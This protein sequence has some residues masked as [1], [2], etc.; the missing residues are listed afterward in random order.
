MRKFWVGFLAFFISIN[1]FSVAGATDWNDSNFSFKYFDSISV[2][3]AM[4]CK[5]TLL[6]YDVAGESQKQTVCI[7][8]AGP[9]K[10]G[11]YAGSNGYNFVVGFH[12]D[13]TLYK[14]VDFDCDIYCIYSPQYDV[15]IA[16]RY[17]V[18]G[19]Q[20]SLTITENFSSRLQS[21]INFNNLTTYFRVT[22]NTP[23]SMFQYDGN[24]FGVNGLGISNNGRYV[25]FEVRQRGIL[26]MDLSNMSLKRV[27]NYGYAYGYGM[28]PGVDLAITNDGNNLVATGGNAG[29]TIYSGLL[30]CG[31]EPNAQKIMD[32][33]PLDLED[34]CPVYYPNLGIFNTGYDYAFAPK[35]TDSG[36]GLRFYAYLYNQG[37]KDIFL[38]LSDS[39]SNQ[40][41]LL[42]LGDSYSSGEGE[43]DHLQYQSSTDTDF[44]NC[45]T[46]LRSYPYLVA[47]T[48]GYGSLVKNVS[49]S[50]AVTG[51]IMG[52]TSDFYWGQKGRLKTI[53]DQNQEMAKE[54]QNQALNNFTPGRIAQMDFVAE[55]QP[56]VITIGIGGNDVGLVGK[57]KSCLMPTT[58]H[59][60]SDP[61]ER[62]KLAG[63]IKSLYDD[64]QKVYLTALSKSP[65]SRIY[66]VSY[67]QII[68]QSSPCDPLTATLF[69][70]TERLFMR[71]TISYLNQV[72]Q[73]AALNVGVKYINIEDVY[74]N[75]TL[76]GQAQASVMNGIVT[77]D[78][79]GVLF[80]R[81]IGNESFHPKPEGHS[82]A[83]Q[84]IISQYPYILDTSYCY[85]NSNICPVATLA[86]N[87]SSYWTAGASQASLDV[88][89]KQLED[90]TLPLDSSSLDKTIAMPAY[91]FNSGSNVVASVHSDY[92]E[93]G[94]FTANQDGSL[95]A[96]LSFPSSLEYGYHTLTLKG[97]TFTGK[98]V[99][100]QQLIF[101]KK[102][103]PQSQSEANNNTDATSSG[104]SSSVLTTKTASSS[105]AS[106]ILSKEK[107]VLGVT[108]SKENFA[109]KQPSETKATYDLFTL[110]ILGMGALSLGLLGAG[111]IKRRIN[112]KLKY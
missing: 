83:A 93:L 63:Q 7:N 53:T 31:D 54:L 46:S 11:Y 99:E 70:A 26:V 86:P 112:N 97:E 72:I 91:S 33:T 56:E 48:F 32:I 96:N 65:K 28:D 90:D 29:F 100:Y 50:G 52:N 78:D 67:P 71:E 61:D 20:K 30:N 88:I 13:R 2:S 43:T 107:A 101:Y 8:E 22:D 24:I 47:S 5:H 19:Y 73:A 77:G 92:V 6:P 94:Q 1:F 25:A 62:A 40:L 109:P 85:N 12:G 89:V 51:D 110:S 79:L 81:L 102:P 42:G 98:Q 41:K 60:A 108:T 49:C 18:N 14:L 45:H 106:P 15:L 37:F 84:E 104:A 9:L 16:R 75:A 38:V 36:N 111:L 35:F 3:E 58:C 44:E 4:W 17:V 82:L 21:Q 95:V 80:L 76:C 103:E 27:T 87:P 69:D 68:S 55:Y 66:A 74:G 34:R 23:T 105:V 10:L 59:Y 57:L 39:S 64:L